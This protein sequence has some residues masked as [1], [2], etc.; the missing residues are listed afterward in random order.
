[1]RI[2]RTVAESAIIIAGILCFW[3][4]ILG[5]HGIGYQTGIL[6]VLALLAVVTVVRVHRV[7]RAFEQAEEKRG[8][9]ESSSEP[10]P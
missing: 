9:D 8:G 5:Y 4:W 10:R 6:V 2:R 3:V 7:K 1:M